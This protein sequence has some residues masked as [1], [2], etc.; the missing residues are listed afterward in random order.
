MTSYTQRNDTGP[1]CVKALRALVLGCLV[2]KDEQPRR[3]QKRGGPRACSYLTF[4]CIGSGSG[5]PAECGACGGSRYPS[6]V[7]D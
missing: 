4:H 5:S 3:L 6:P 7:R 2:T 1:G